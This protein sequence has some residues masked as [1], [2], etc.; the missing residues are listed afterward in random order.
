MSQKGGKLDHSP[1]SYRWW[2]SPKPW[3][4]MI[5]GGWL[6]YPIVEPIFQR[7]C[8][9]DFP[10]DFLVMFMIFPWFSHGFSCDLHDF[11]HRCS[12]PTGPSVSWVLGSQST[13]TKRATKALAQDTELVKRVAGVGIDVPLWQ[14]HHPTT[15]L[16]YFSSQ[17]IILNPQYNTSLYLIIPPFLLAKSLFF[18]D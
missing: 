7:W 10:M 12:A 17:I 9:H 15:L 3:A 13:C 1:F 11:G 5:Y 6:A 4:Y 2:K 18:F 8:S 14:S 16:G